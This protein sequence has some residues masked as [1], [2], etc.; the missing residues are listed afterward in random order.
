MAV[1]P[2]NL[3]WHVFDLTD[4]ERE[5][6][7]SLATGVVENDIL[8]EYQGYFDIVDVCVV[9]SRAY[10]LEYRR[11]I[12]PTSDVDLVVKVRWQDGVKVYPAMQRKNVLLEDKFAFK[13]AIVHL[14]IASHTHDCSYSQYGYSLP[15]YSLMFNKYH[16]PSNV[17][18]MARMFYKFHITPT[19]FKCMRC[20]KELSPT[21]MHIVRF[22]EPHTRIDRRAVICSKCLVELLEG[23]LKFMEDLNG[24]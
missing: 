10:P 14:Y 4:E 18:I 21:E 20:G 16:L 5:Q 12:R 13:G 11:F 3:T 8:R 2:E 19:D 23:E 6:L 15:Y 1:I 22:N 17:D 9:G 7:M 24:R